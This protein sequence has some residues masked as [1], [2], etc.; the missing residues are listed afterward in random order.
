MD[1][2]E[3]L[4][5]YRSLDPTSSSRIKSTRFRDPQTPTKPVTNDQHNSTS[6]IAYVINQAADSYRFPSVKPMRRGWAIPNSQP[7]YDISSAFPRGQPPLAR[8]GWNSSSDRTPS[9]SIGSPHPSAVN[10]AARI[11]ALQHHHVVSIEQV[12]SF[13]FSY[14]P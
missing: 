10:D 1:K 6:C 2:P 7:R 8:P 12:R 11:V 3:R 4:P 13:S 14:T 5:S 9:Y